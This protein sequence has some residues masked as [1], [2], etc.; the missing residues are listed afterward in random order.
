MVTGGNEEIFLNEKT[1]ICLNA[2]KKDPLDRR[3][4]G[5]KI[6]KRG[7][8]GNGILSAVGGGMALWQE[9]SSPSPT[10]AEGGNN[11]YRDR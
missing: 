9:R 6:I 3:W 8:E 2:G 10:V 7:Q 4:R 1:C 11:G 5:R